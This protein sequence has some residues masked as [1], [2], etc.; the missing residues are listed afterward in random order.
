M[1]T[2]Q[3]FFTTEYRMTSDD[4]NQLDNLVIVGKDSYYHVT[5]FTNEVS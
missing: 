1:G 2:M 5:V 3:L 4:T